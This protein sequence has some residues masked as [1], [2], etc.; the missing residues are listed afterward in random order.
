MKEEQEKAPKAT[1]RK[2]PP[3]AKGPASLLAAST[4]TLGRA[5]S[6]DPFYKALFQPKT[7][8]R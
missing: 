6:R 8:S 1:S 4:S 5:S 3:K 2:A 7:D